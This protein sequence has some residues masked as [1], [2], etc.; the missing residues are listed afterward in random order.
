MAEREYDL[1]LFGGTGFTGG[2]TAEYLAAHATLGCRWAL[3]GRDPAKLERLRQRLARINPDLED[4]PLIEADVTDS[5]SLRRLVE[6]TRVVI[7]TVG[8]YLHYGEPLVAACAAGGTDYVDLTGEPE[9]V[10]RMYLAHH[11][12]ARR[13]G[14]RIVHAC[15]F[16]SVP[17]DLGVYFTVQHLPKGVP[18]T[19]EGQVRAHAEFSGGTYASL[20]TAL[21]RP[22]RMA[23]AARR[24]REVEPRPE[25]RR[26]HLPNGPLYRDRETGRWQVPL[27]TIDPR[28]VGFSAAA[29]DRYGPDFTYRHY[30]SVKRLPTIAAAALGLVLLGVLAQIPPARRALG[31][32]RKPGEGPSAQRRLRSWFT[33]R[34]V[35]EG[36]GERVVTEFAGGDPGY[37]ETAKMLAESAL[38]LAFDQLPATSGQVTTAAAMGDALLNRLASAGMTIRVVRRC[39]PDR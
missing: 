5:G 38:C 9:F 26:V 8:P 37:D 22:T 17:Y 33:V 16:D 1:V 11:E 10:D 13:T 25:N 20:L 34:F 28:I 35:G 31:T 12:T 27:P 15:G 19:V 23:R 29:L 36:G 32:L 14:A 4:L 7:T 24:R 39:R 6:S 30:A 21:S 3:A 18:L 2:L